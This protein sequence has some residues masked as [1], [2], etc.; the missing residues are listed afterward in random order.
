MVARAWRSLGSVERRENVSWSG[1]GAVPI[2][3]RGCSPPLTIAFNVFDAVAQRCLT[4]YRALQI[5]FLG[6]EDLD[7]EGC[8][9]MLSRLVVN[10]WSTHHLYNTK[11]TLLSGRASHNGP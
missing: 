2:S 7:V 6:F 9:L 11:S 8:R 3:S 5:T 10:C 1:C 4:L